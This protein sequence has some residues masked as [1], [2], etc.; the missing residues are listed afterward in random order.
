MFFNRNFSKTYSTLDD[1][2]NIH[3]P[4][5]IQLNYIF[6]FIL[7]LHISEIRITILDSIELLLR[8]KYIKINI[9]I[10]LMKNIRFL[11]NI[12]IG[13]CIYDLFLQ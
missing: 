8:R 6:L 4:S 10:T 5:I 2:L 7:I 1:L 11:F 13:N 9:I 12:S 3:V